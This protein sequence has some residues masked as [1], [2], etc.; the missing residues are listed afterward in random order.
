MTKLN[1]I[2]TVI[3][4]G[5]S[6]RTK[7]QENYK[8]EIAWIQVSDIKDDDAFVH[9]NLTKIEA[10]N[11]KERDFLKSGDVLLVAKGPKHHATWLPSLINPSIASSNLIIIRPKPRR[12]N[13]E[14][15]V[16]YLNQDK[17]QHYLESHS[18]GSGMSHVT[19]PVVGNMHI[20]LPPLEEQN[21]IVSVLA[22]TRDEVDIMEKMMKKRTSIV[23][24]RLL[25]MLEKRLESLKKSPRR[26]L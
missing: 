2:C 20:P 21:E 23:N 9:Q 5:R 16:W 22:S 26:S 24:A 10:I 12:L 13:A 7:P 25:K 18:S 17:A 4:S 1:Q 15:L 3:Q 11:L 14:D 8:G 6:F 19:I